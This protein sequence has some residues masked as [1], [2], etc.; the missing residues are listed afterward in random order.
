VP[1]AAAVLG[2]LE[3]VQRFVLYRDL[4]L[5]EIRCRH[6]ESHRAEQLRLYNALNARH[7]RR[8]VRYQSDS[9]F[10][11]EPSKT[12]A[13]MWLIEAFAAIVVALEIKMPSSELGDKTSMRIMVARERLIE[14]RTSTVNKWIINRTSYGRSEVL[15]AA[16]IWHLQRS[17]IDNWR[18]SCAYPC[19]YTG[20]SSSAPAYKNHQAPTA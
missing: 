9:D 3:P 10:N 4:G 2:L 14:L 12:A 1:L 7:D 8:G 20:V 13:D 16:N 19:R 17:T 11:V 6:E 18:S 15:C 5:D